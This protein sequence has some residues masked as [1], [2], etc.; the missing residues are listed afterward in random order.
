MDF[1]YSRIAARAQ[2]D[3][4]DTSGDVRG[5]HLTTVTAISDSHPESWRRRGLESLVQ[6]SLSESGCVARLIPLFV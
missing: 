1:R 2:Q 5:V 3:I 6:C 4:R